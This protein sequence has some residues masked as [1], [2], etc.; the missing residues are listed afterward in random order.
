MDELTPLPIEGPVPVPS[1]GRENRAPGRPDDFQTPSIALLPLLPYLRP[2]WHIW[3]PACGQGNLVRA[4]AERGYRVTGT[5]VL[6]GQN[7]HDIA[8]DCDCILTNPPYR[9]KDAFLARCYALGKPFAL[10]MPLTALEGRVRQTFYRERGVEVI[11]M[12][13]RINFRTPSGTGKSSWFPTAWFT[14][15]LGIGQAMTFAQLRPVPQAE[16]RQAISSG[17]NEGDSP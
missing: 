14:W 8:L 17:G 10:L 3:E 7:F 1:R 16:R 12:D 15:G 6:Q 5:D 2:Q 9:S 13:R 4:L 11:F